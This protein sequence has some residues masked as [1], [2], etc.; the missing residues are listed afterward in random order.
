[1]AIY[2][3]TIH[4]ITDGNIQELHDFAKS[5]GMKKNW[6]QNHRKPHYDLFGTMKQKAIEKGAVLKSSREL[7]LILNMIK[8]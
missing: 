3:D 8:R 6:F 2:T 7:V 5:M 4:L 1:M